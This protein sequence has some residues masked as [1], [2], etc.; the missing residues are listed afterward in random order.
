MYYPCLETQLDEFKLLIL[1]FFN[2]NV[3]EQFADANFV[4][5]VYIDIPPNNKVWLVDFNPW[6]S[7]TDPGLFE[8]S[9][10]MSHPVSEPPVW[11]IITEET[12]VRANEMAQ[13]KVPAEI[14]EAPNSAEVTQFFDSMR[15]A[16]S[17]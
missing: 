4:F 9:E 10:V 14:V 16:K 13:Y 7:K 11:R 8:W 12:G 17:D 15:E 6:H 5:D 3:R 1:D 2:D